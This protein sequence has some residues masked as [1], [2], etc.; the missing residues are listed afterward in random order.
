MAGGMR[1]GFLWTKKFLIDGCRSRSVEFDDE[2][3]TA[4]VTFSF[5]S[6]PPGL[7]FKTVSYDQGAE[8]VRIVTAHFDLLNKMLDQFL[9]FIPPIYQLR[10]YHE[11]FIIDHMSLQLYRPRSGVCA[12]VGSGG[13]AST[14]FFFFASSNRLP[15]S[16]ICSTNSSDRSF[17]Y[18]LKFAD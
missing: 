16:R 2:L 9:A 7:D 4:A 6:A 18:A 17:I 11:R 12:G 15:Y 3:R 13:I 10:K 14:G 8:L 5:I 1:I